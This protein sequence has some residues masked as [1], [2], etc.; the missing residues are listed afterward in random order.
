VELLLH[1]L[2]QC[3]SLTVLDISDNG[4]SRENVETLLPVVLQLPLLHRLNLDGSN[5]SRNG[6][7]TKPKTRHL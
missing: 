7:K 2:P 5:T 3:F 4:L 1:L 6:L